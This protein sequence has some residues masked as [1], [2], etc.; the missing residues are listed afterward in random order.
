MTAPIAPWLAAALAEA[1]TRTQRVIDQ[2]ADSARIRVRFAFEHARR[3]MGQRLRT[4]R[5]TGRSARS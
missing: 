2:S 1:H 3:S 5:L 4:D